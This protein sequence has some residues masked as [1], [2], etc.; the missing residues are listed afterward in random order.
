MKA[1]SL[2]K[3]RAAGRGEEEAR[4]P[5]RQRRRR[6]RRHRGRS[7]EAEA[8][9]EKDASAASSSSSSASSSAKI[10]PAQPHE[11]DAGDHRK[12]RLRGGEEQREHGG[13]MHEHCDKCCSPLEDGG[14]GA[15]DEEEVAA[16]AADRDRE[17]AAEPE[18]GVLMTLVSRGDGTNHLRRIR[19][20]EEYFGDAWAAQS[21]WADNCD[22]I[23]ELYSVVVQPEHPSHSDEDDDD[24]PAA[25]VTPCQSEDDDHQHPVRV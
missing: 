13:A 24:D 14:G 12:D 1:L 2:I 11:G 9:Q 7:Q 21:W 6:R 8:P 19:F 10:A 17:W 15:A 4:A 3:V 22:R 23:V 5:R 25:P 18:P 20:S 16:G